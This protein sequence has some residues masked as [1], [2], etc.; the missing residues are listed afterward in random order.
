MRVWVFLGLVLAA[1]LYV[2][3]VAA[4]AAPTSGGPIMAPIA[5]CDLPQPSEKAALLFASY[6]EGAAVSPVRVGDGSKGDTTSVV[7]VKVRPGIGPLYVVISGSRNSIL[8]FSGW[9]NRLERLVVATK[10]QYP[11]AVS[12]MPLDRIHFV[13]RDDCASTIRLDDL[14]KHAK[15]RQDMSSVSMVVRRPFPESMGAEERSKQKTPYRMPDAIGGTYQPE[16]LTLSE[17]GVGFTDYRAHTHG[18]VPD[19]F[20]RARAADFYPGGIGLVDLEQLVTP[21][22]AVPYAILPDRAGIAQ[23]IRDEKV[24]DHGDGNYTILAPI[25]LPEGLCGAMSA[26]FTLAPGVPAPSGDLCHSHLR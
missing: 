7:E 25:E 18:S 24:E 9:T 12:G 4:V 6:Y 13:D 5:G 26:T 21:A 16:V 23:L 11:V 19:W 8:N 22:A 20:E 2:D 10:A 14:Y 1:W 15:A 17:F 3:R